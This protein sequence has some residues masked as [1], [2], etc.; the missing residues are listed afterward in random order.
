M[1]DIPGTGNV[2]HT[3]PHDS[4]LN[5]V[6]IYTTWTP[7]RLATLRDLLDNLSL[8]ARVNLPGSVPTATEMVLQDT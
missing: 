7:M 4:A 8:S 5:L 6:I 1:L 3:V 2:R